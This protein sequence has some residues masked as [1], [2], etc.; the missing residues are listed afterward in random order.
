MDPSVCRDPNDT[1]LLGL[2]QHISADFLV[3]GDKDLLDLGRFTC[4]SSLSQREAGR[5][6]CF[7]SLSQREAGRDLLEGR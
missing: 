2:V 4:F 5:D 6:S 7:S 3:T 1:H